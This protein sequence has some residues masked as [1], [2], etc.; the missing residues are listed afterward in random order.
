V[1]VGGGANLQRCRALAHWL[2]QVWSR[3]HRS[4]T[5]KPEGSCGTPAVVVHNLVSDLAFA[6]ATGEWPV[7]GH[8]TVMSIRPWSASKWM[9]V[10]A[11]PLPHEQLSPSTGRRLPATARADQVSRTAPRAA[12]FVGIWSAYLVGD[13]LA[14]VSEQLRALGGLELPGLRLLGLATHDLV[15]PIQPRRP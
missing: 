12:L 2:S 14:G 6:A 11:T 13:G 3:F 4:S 8:R 7:L 10:V 15:H 5:G 1:S 9:A